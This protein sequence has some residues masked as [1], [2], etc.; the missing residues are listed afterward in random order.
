[1]GPRRAA[2]S[3]GGEAVPLP[4]SCRVDGDAVRLD[5][6]GVTAAATTLLLPRVTLAAASARAVGTREVRAAAARVLAGVLAAPAP[7]PAPA[8]ATGSA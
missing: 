6:D 4:D 7:A 1:M 3:R 2:R 8:P 5:F